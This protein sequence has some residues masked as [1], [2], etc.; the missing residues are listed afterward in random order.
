MS[1]CH[2]R[3][4]DYAVPRARAYSSR[5]RSGVHRCLCRG[6]H[7]RP[8]VF[9]CR[10]ESAWRIISCA[11]SSSGRYTHCPRSRGVGSSRCEDALSMR[12]ASHFAGRRRPLWESSANMERSAA[13][14]PF[15]NDEPSMSHYHLPRTRSS[16]SCRSAGACL[17]ACTPSQMSASGNMHM[18][19]QAGHTLPVTAGITSVHH[20]IKLIPGVTD[21]GARHG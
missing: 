20:C 14:G 10:I 6:R 11:R 3:A 2:R 21:H 15:S 16:G 13:V 19:D 1:V 8:S 18:Y 4:H 5:Q 17:S 12:T 9:A 7:D